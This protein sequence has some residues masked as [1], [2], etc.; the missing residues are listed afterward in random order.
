M[1]KQLPLILDL[2]SVM[3]IWRML[4]RYLVIVISIPLSIFFLLSDFVRY[5][6]RTFYFVNKWLIILIFIAATKFLGYLKTFGIL[7]SCLIAMSIVMSWKMLIA[8]PLI[9][10]KGWYW[11]RHPL[12]FNCYSGFLLELISLFSLLHSILF[13]F[14]WLMLLYFYFL[15][16]AEFL[17]CLV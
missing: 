15:A 14:H 4:G 1:K 2:R 12:L 6:S 9:S 11:A 5:S 10:G 17:W 8:T 16:S 7:L 13:M 3:E